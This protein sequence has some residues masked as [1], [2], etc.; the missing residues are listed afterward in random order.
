M[1]KY[2]DCFMFGSNDS[3]RKKPVLDPDLDESDRLGRF[4]Y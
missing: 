4:T 1:K 3:P 2:N